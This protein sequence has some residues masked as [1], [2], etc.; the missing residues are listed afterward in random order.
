[1]NNCTKRLKFGLENILKA[2]MK[3]LE[4]YTAKGLL[5]G[6]IPSSALVKLQ[7]DIYE[8]VDKY[9]KPRG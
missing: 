4:M 7:N 1:M 3:M 2:A 8:F 6:E 5:D 9:L